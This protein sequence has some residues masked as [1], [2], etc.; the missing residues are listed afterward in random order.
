MGKSA[1]CLKLHSTLVEKLSLYAM[2]DASEGL[3]AAKVFDTG[4]DHGAVGDETTG[5]ISSYWRT[6]DELGPVKQKQHV[7]F[8][9][10]P[11]YVEQSTEAEILVTGSIEEAV[12]KAQKLA[13][14]G[15]V[16]SNRA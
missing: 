4:A 15:C 14:G 2:D 3:F 6:V 10:A 5:R 1:L 8:Q 7:L 11:E 16:S 9:D 13:A 12:E